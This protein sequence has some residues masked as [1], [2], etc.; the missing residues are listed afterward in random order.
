MEMKTAARAL[1]AIGNESRL[2]VYRMLIEAGPAGLAAGKLAE[3]AGMPPSSLSFHLKEL[4]HADLLE[5]RQ[6]G[7]FVIYAAKYQTMTDLIGF[8]T[9]NCCGGNPCMPVAEQCCNT[10]S[11]PRA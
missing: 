6:E 10:Q 11:A 4:V 2:L 8:L 5:S 3:L 7:R 1:T 9:D